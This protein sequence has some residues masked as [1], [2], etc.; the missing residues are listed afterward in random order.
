MNLSDVSVGSVVT[1]NYVD[2]KGNPS[3]RLVKVNS[4]NGNYMDCLDLVKKQ[5]RRFD[6]RVA[7]NVE[8]LG[9]N[10]DVV[11]KGSI[12]YKDYC[13]SMGSEVEKVEYLPKYNLL[14]IHKI[15]KSQSVTVDFSEDGFCLRFLNKKNNELSWSGDSKKNYINNLPV[16]SLEDLV[17]KLYEHVRS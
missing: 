2:V 13:N 7:F 8:V 14:A 10:V 5:P 4:V 3:E 11:E 12:E 16:T 17:T 15:K 6:T 9:E 1:F